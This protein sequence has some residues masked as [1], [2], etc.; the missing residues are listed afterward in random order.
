MCPTKRGQCLIRKQCCRY[1]N[2]AFMFECG[3][4]FG[5]LSGK[6]DEEMVNALMFMDGEIISNGV[7]DGLDGA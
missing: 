1:K 2:V 7:N 5:I 4:H 6:Y 3:V